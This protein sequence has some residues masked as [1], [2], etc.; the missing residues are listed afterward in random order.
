MDDCRKILV[1][2]LEALNQ[3]L[4]EHQIE[5]LLTYIALIEKWNKSY[6][7]TSIRD[8]V[9]MVPMHLLDS[10]AK[11][12]RFVQQAI[13]ELKLTNVS[14]CHNRVELYHPDNGFDIAITRAF[15]SLEDIMRLTTHL[16]N[17]GGVLLA[18]K[19]QIPDVSMLEAAKTELYPLSVPGI[20]GE[21][22]LVK[23]HL[24]NVAEV[25]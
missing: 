4:T 3:E 23:I 6:N 1:S 10:N 5:Q 25:S 9:S 24:N 19:G 12:T 17:N 11:K 14:I 18:M 15:A 22:C 16:L 7:L 20:E 2:G 13:L 21:R 8:K